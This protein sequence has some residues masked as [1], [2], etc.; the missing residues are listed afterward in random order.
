MRGEGVLARREPK[1]SGR[2]AGSLVFYPLCPRLL[3]PNPNAG[4]RKPTRPL[5]EVNKPLPNPNAGVR[6]PTRPLRNPGVGVR[7]INGPL[8][9]LSGELRNLNGPLPKPSGEV[10]NWSGGVQRASLP[11]KA[12]PSEPGNATW[13]FA[14][15][16]KPFPTHVGKGFL[17]KER[18]VLRSGRMA[19][20]HAS[21]GHLPPA[22]S[23]LSSS[24]LK[25]TAAR[26]C[27]GRAGRRVCRPRAGSRRPG[28]GER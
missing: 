1:P 12:L 16:T 6:K 15:Q 7:N 14:L 22:F 11:E 21:Q 18:V 24:P 23:T 19:S 17:V 25:I 28:R 8:P 26:R 27:R 10:R 9:N 2:C 4:V 13:N 5:P 20:A 3:V